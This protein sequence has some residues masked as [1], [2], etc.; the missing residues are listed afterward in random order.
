MTPMNVEVVIGRTDDEG[1]ENGY[2]TLAHKG[3][4][5]SLGYV[6]AEGLK[7]ISGADLE[8]TATKFA[9]FL[10]ESGNGCVFGFC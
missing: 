1:F 9:L 8:T 6:W 5:V 4:T 2:N 3:L 10:S 7:L